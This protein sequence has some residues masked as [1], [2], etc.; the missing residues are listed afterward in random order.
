MQ[1]VN[2]GLNAG[3]DISVIKNVIGCSSLSAQIYGVELQFISNRCA[4]DLS[5]ISGKPEVCPKLFLW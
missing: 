3:S 4:L 2:G 1:Q 5:V